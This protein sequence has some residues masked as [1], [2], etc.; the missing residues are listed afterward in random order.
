MYDRRRQLKDKNFHLHKISVYDILLIG[1][2]VITPILSLSSVWHQDQDK[3]EA[4]I[5]RNNKLLEVHDLSQD[6]V[7]SISD[8]GIEMTI[9][10]DGG[11]IRVLESNCPKH[12]CVHIGWIAG[13]GQT[14]VCVPNKMLVEVKGKQSLKYHAESY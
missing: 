13:S 4:L 2:L 1:M 11:R 3:K 10:I 8:K 9:K 14:I 7:I 5:Y 12:I 6:R